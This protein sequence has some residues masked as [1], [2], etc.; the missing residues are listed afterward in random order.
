MNTYA[1][2]WHEVVTHTHPELHG[3]FSP[4]LSSLITKA[5]QY[6]IGR[7][8]SFQKA[9]YSDADFSKIHILINWWNFLNSET[10]HEF[11]DKETTDKIQDTILYLVTHDYP[12]SVYAVYCPSYKT[13]DGVSGYNGAIGTYTQRMIRRMS[14][15]VYGSQTAGIKTLGIAY[16]SDLLLENYEA[17]RG[18][19]YKTDL[20]ENYEDFRST[21]ARYDPHKII[22]TTLLS[23][24]PS[25]KNRIGEKGI[26]D[27]DI[28]VPLS[29]MNVVL[30][31][32]EVFYKNVLG[33]EDEE[34]RLRTE[35]LGR[36]YSCM[37]DTFRQL[38]N[39]GIMF[40]TES[41]YERG[42]MYSGMRQN[43]PL[44]IIYPPKIDGTS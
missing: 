27:G 7:A 31:R 5:R 39:H 29:V 12:L 28:P 8:L 9:Q 34:I 20:T 17:L 24:I 43:N 41:A 18:T 23:N 33:W 37:G 4:D 35:T 19:S 36:C 22:A 10:S 1:F 30:K 25:L 42:R 2:T 3:I 14:D 16:F 44:P 26:T 6:G 15:F 32:N 40:W 13:G 11:R 21:F 38:Y